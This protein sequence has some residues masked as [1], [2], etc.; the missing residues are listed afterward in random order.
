MSASSSSAPSCPDHRAGPCAFI[1]GTARTTYTDL[2]AQANRIA[3]ELISRG[4][5]RG[6]TAGVGLN[7][8]ETLIAALLDVWKTGAACV[9]LD[10]TYPA[11]RLEFIV[12]DAGVPHTVT[13]AALSER[14][15][16]RDLVLTDTLGE[17]PWNDLDLPSDPA[18][19]RGRGRR[20]RRRSGRGPGRGRRRPAGGRRPRPVNGSASTPTE[21]TS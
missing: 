19:R 1:A 18:A 16:E 15:P 20:D 9:P 4:V 3:H 11:D 2:D 12:E 14:L 7:R 8:D 10:S 5:G 17:R 13:S 6:S 21:R